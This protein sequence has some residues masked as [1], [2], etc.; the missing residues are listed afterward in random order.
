MEFGREGLTKYRIF[1][2]HPSLSHARRFYP[3]AHNLDGFFVCKLKKLSNKI[4]TAEVPTT[5][6]EAPDQQAGSAMQQQEGVN[7]TGTGANLGSKSNKVKK[8]KTS[9]K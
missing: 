5:Q 1:R 2:F 4:P 7:A 6:D 9:A 3:H 8:R